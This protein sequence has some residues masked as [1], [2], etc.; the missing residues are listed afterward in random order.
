MKRWYLYIILY[1]LAGVFGLSPFRGNDLAVL[2]PVEVVWLEAEQGVVRIETDNGDVGVGDTVK[3]A[4]ENMKATA[5]AEIFLDTADYLIVKQGSEALIEQM[6]ESIRPSC[7]LC[8]AQ[9]IPDMKKVA[10]FLSV[11]EPSVKMK[12]GF[13]GVES[14]PVLQERKGRLILVEQ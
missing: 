14:L 2:S 10:A 12:N 6:R 9:K 8:A 13:K 1:A 3:A 5:S 11:H 4:L 7:S